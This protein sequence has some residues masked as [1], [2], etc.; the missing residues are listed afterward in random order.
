MPL[1]RVLVLYQQLEVID[2]QMEFLASTFTSRRPIAL[3]AP[4]HHG[5]NTPIF[6]MKQSDE[7]QGIIQLT[8]F[9]LT[10][11]CNI[12]SVN[13]LSGCLLALCKNKR[14]RGWKERKRRWATE[15]NGSRELYLPTYDD[16]DRMDHL[17]QPE[18]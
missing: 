6:A 3:G 2:F 16:I 4:K 15:M 17:I 18:L 10:L 11:S 14:K 13:A 9:Q 1:K 7:T 5:S 12:G 8:T